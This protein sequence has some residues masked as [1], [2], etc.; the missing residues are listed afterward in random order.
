MPAYLTKSV[1][2]SLNTSMP[3]YAPTSGMLHMQLQHMHI[4]RCICRCIC[5]RC[6]CSVPTSGM[7]HMH[8]H[9]ACCTCTYIRHAAYAPTEGM[10]LHRPS[11]CSAPPPLSMLTASPTASSRACCPYSYVGTYAGIRASYICCWKAV[12]LLLRSRILM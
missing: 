11:H 9:Q 3:A 7:L 6:I 8:L 5:C 1:S 12:G 2:M 4:Q 10:H